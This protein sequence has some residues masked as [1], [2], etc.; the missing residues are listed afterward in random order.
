MELIEVNSY[1]EKIE[2]APHK[3]Y[4]LE[5]SYEELTLFKLG[6]QEILRKFEPFEDITEET[7]M[8]VVGIDGDK[9]GWQHGQNGL[10]HGVVMD[11]RP[12]AIHVV[13]WA[14]PKVISM[15]KIPGISLPE[16]LIPV[17]RK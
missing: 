16:G 3:I 15:D 6:A 7:N 8:H 13:F 10:T 11:F 2:K 14:K 9:G 17:T 12:L 1:I 5:M 4:I